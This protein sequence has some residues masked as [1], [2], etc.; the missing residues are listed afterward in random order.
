MIYVNILE[1]EELQRVVK[2]FVSALLP[3]K[4]FKKEHFGEVLQA[5]TSYIKL[6][7]FS[8]EYFVILSAITELNRINLSVNNVP[9]LTKDIF[10][11]IVEISVEDLLNNSSVRIKEYLE[12]EG[13]NSNLSVQ[14]SREAAMQRL[15]TRSMELYDECF[16]M[17]I[18]TNEA[19]SYLPAYKSAF[20]AR[21]MLDSAN[22]QSTIIMKGC[23][24]GKSFYS[25][26]Q[27]CLEY[28]TH[29][30]NVVNERLTDVENNSSLF[31]VDSYAK[32]KEMDEALKKAFIPIAYWGIP[33][34]DGNDI[35]PGTPI[36]RY[37]LNVIVGGVNIGKSMF[38]KDAATQV[39][40]QGG[41]VL[42]MYGEGTKEDVWAG[43][44]INYI[45]KKFQK[46]VTTQMLIDEESQPEEIRKII[47]LAKA[48][49]FESGS[50]SFREAYDYDHIYDQVMDDYKKHNFDLL[51]VDHSLALK[52]SGKTASENVHNMSIA[53]RD[54]KRK[55]PIAVIVASHP[56]SAAKEWMTRDGKIPSEIAT[57]RESSTLEAEA[58]F[59]YLLRSNAILE[60]QGLIAL[61]DKKRRRAGHL[62]EQVILTKMFDVCHF[63]Y[64]PA[65]QATEELDRLDAESALLEMEQAYK[66][67]DLEEA[68]SLD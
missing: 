57:T 21:T 51:I 52:S 33:E 36:L 39:V 13:M 20:L 38:C 6:E 12:H 49:L 1:D 28:L 29:L 67:E 24:I 22:V 50:V 45:Y 46:F 61:E 10:S 63:E 41:K 7:E 59:L 15:Y 31:I 68:Y 11:D 2:T 27:E 9:Y 40:T 37:T 32:I 56:S 23:W 5:T 43:I 44:L 3:H 53:L 17:A 30:T 4:N 18:P 48:E 14:T 54:V 19:I 42:Y 47:R 65:R 35:V 64:D 34:L 62:Q 16:D 8:M 58:D 25:G 60:K 26:Y 55:L 66:D